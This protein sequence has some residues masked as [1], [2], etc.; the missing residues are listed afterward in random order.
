[1][2]KL[3]LLAI[4][5]GFVFNSCKNDDDEK[6]ISIIGNWKHTQLRVISGKNGNVLKDND[7]SACEQ[8]GTTEFTTNGIAKATDY[9]DNNGAC[10]SYYEEYGYTYNKGAKKITVDGSV[11]TVK[12]LTENEMILDD[13]DATYDYNDDGY[14]DLFELHLTR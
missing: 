8:K 14:N 5:A 11:F 9:D 2:K 7:L 1:M 3:I 6:E 4:C 12:S 10:T 13:V